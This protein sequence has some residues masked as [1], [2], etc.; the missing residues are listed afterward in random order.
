MDAASDGSVP[1]L[2]SP[3]GNFISD[4]SDADAKYGAEVATD[5]R[6][7]PRDD[8][9]DLDVTIAGCVFPLED[10]L[11]VAE[12]LC[13]HPS[14][15]VYPKQL[16]SCLIA[17]CE[18]VHTGDVEAERK[19]VELTRLYR[20]T[21]P[22]AFEKCVVFDDVVN[23]DRN[24]QLDI[25]VAC[26]ALAEL[27][28]VKLSAALVSS[29]RRAADE[30]RGRDGDAETDTRED[31]ETPEESDALALL[32][33]LTW[34]FDRA[35]A[36]HANNRFEPVPRRHRNHD[37]M[38][39]VDRGLHA[40]AFA[41]VPSDAL[42]RRDGA[43]ADGVIDITADDS[44]ATARGGDADGFGYEL[45]SRDGFGDRYAFGR[46]ASLRAAN[47]SGSVRPGRVRLE[48]GL[49]S[50]CDAGAGRKKKGLADAAGKRR[51]VPAS[52][53]TS[54]SVRSPARSRWSRAR[55]ARR[56]V[57]WTHGR[58]ENSPFRLPLPA[59]TTRRTKG[60]RD[61]NEKTNTVE[62]FSSRAFADARRADARLRR[63]AERRVSEA[64]RAVIEDRSA[65]TRSTRSSQRCA[66]STMPES[67]R[68]DA[69]GLGAA[70]SAAAATA[71][72]SWIAR[73]RCGARAAPD[74]PAPQAVRGPALRAL[75][76][77][78]RSARW[79]T[80]TWT[81]CGTSRSGRTRSRRPARTSPRS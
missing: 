24:I 6:A 66:K 41:A 20:E 49:A 55:R 27:V 28:S 76:H 42:R 39:D 37:L 65:C 48:R 32:T 63:R 58:P 80:R 60:P 3:V 70:E 62:T 8:T 33:A 5:A 19:S 44:D 21:T 35:S 12:G 17:A 46:G 78:S 31:E 61:K 22:S 40:A 13:R 34:T 1:P 25:L 81:R 50:I 30:A 14:W 36:F 45:D 4:R 56:G 43:D 38:V 74:V 53:P 59:T 9:S 51:R 64:H 73:E 7:S 75:R 79:R 23:W 52:S 29:P 16:A 26:K 72:T 68:G 10:Y 11:Q 71:A 69:S 77:L 54:A 57:T 67:A 15:M 47:T 18:I 2:D